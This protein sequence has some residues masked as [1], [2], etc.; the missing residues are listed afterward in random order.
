VLR[1]TRGRLSYANV[2]S[3]IAV[4]VALGGTTYAAATITGGDVKNGSL[5]GK[6]IKRNSLNGKQIVES[7]L[8][9]VRRARNAALFGGRPPSRYLVHCPTGT[10]P[11]ASVCVETQ[12]RPPQPYSNAAGECDRVDRPE[13]PG[14]RLPSHDELMLALTYDPIQ[15]APDG[16]LTRNVRHVGDNVPLEVLTVVTNTG[17]TTTVP[18]TAAAGSRPFRCVASPIN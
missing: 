15:L 4:F 16:E 5:T 17:G 12:P 14:R 3:T 1:V 13:T 8:G 2:M 10:T 9:T 18:D 11:L 7:R 6:D